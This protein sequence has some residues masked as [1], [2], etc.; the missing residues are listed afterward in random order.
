MSATPHRLIATAAIVAAILGVGSN[1]AAAETG[2]FA[3]NFHFNCRPDHN[4]G[5]PNGSVLVLRMGW[6]A[7]NR[8]LLESFLNGHEMT[9]VIDG[10]PLADP[11]QYWSEPTYDPVQDWWITRWTYNTGIA[12]T[13]DNPFTIEIAGIAT[14]P[15]LDGIVAAGDHDNRPLLAEPG[16]SLFDSNGP[17]SVTAF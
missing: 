17:C 7:K 15:V 4:I 2:T 3:T 14:H 10:V 13:F 6:A 16:A 5:V 8:G 9:A 1:V 11:A 12:V